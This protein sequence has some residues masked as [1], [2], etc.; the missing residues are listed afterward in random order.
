M[1]KKIEKLNLMKQKKIL[2]KI[3]QKKKKNE[4]TNFDQLKKKFRRFCKNIK[5]KIINN[6]INKK[7]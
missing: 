2:L 3:Y 4:K 1:K 6:I 7:T 5:S